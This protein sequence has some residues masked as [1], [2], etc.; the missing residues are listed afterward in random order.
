LADRFAE[1]GGISAFCAEAGHVGTGEDVGWCDLTAVFSAAGDDLV[2]NVTR[3]TIALLGDEPIDRATLN[4]TVDRAPLDPG[5]YVGVR[6]SA[7]APRMTAIAWLPTEGSAQ[8][9]E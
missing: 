2:Q 8:D 9:A 5:I 7:A 1:P 6:E 4:A 3:E